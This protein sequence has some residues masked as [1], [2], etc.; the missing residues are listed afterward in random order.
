MIPLQNFVQETK[1]EKEEIKI[2][3]NLEIKEMEKLIT[4]EGN[5]LRQKYL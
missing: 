1:S 4:I 3:D 5:L 2:M